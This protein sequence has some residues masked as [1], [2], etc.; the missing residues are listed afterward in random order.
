M[1][2]DSV[3]AP[4]NGNARLACQIVGTVPN[5]RVQ[6]IRM[7]G[8]PLPQNSYENG[9]EL[10]IQNVQPS[11]GGPYGCQAV[12][13]AGRVVFTATTNLRVSGNAPK[14]LAPKM[15]LIQAL[16]AAP[17]RISLEPQFQVV[18]PGDDAGISCSATGEQPIQIEWSKLGQPY[19]PRSVYARGGRLDF[20]A[21]STDDQ[22]RYVC[23]ASNQIGTSEATAEVIVR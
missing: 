21:I 23:T 1:V 14:I 15:S 12:D 7:D 2:Q 8:Q 3:L 6:W 13:P 17:P 11:D 10:Y 16:F 9:G 18:R 4:V 20:R 5:L 19:L 22:G